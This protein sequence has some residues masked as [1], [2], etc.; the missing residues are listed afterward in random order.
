[1]WLKVTEKDKHCDA[2]T[3]CG[4]TSQNEL[5]TVADDKTIQQWNINAEFKKKMCELEHYPTSFSFATAQTKSIG[6]NFVVGFSNGM[7]QLVSK[8]GR[9]ERKVASAHKGA[10]LTCKFNHEGTALMTAG[11]DGFLK[12]WSKTGN[13]QSKLCHNAR[14]VYDLAWAP[15][16]QSV[17]YCSEKLLTIKPLSPSMKEV[18][19]K[20]HDA[21]VLAVDWNPINNLIISGGEDCRYKIWDSFGRQM[22]ASS[23]LEFT[24][25]SIAWANSGDV[26]AV[27]TYN[28]ILLCDRYGWAH[29][30]NKLRTGSI[31]SLAWTAD[32][33]QVAGA[34]ASGTVCFAQCLGKSK[35]WGGIVA[36]V[37]DLKHVHVVG[38]KDVAVN[39]SKLSISE[40]AEEVMRE[41]EELEFSDRVVEVS[42]GHGHVV[43]VTQTACYI[44]KTSTYALHHKFELSHGAITLLMMSTGIFLLAS[45]SKGVQIYST[46]GSLRCTPRGQHIAPARFLH[47][48]NTA[49]AADVLAH[50][51][52][53]NPREVI[54][55][56]TESGK[57]YAEPYTHSL[58]VAQIAF[59]QTASTSTRKL[60]II[61][62]NRDLYIT[63][64]HRPDAFKLAT[65]VDTAA[66]HS[67]SDVLACVSHQRLVT[68][69]YP[70]VVY[71]DRDLLPKIQCSTDA[72][73]Y[74]KQSQIV[75]FHG[76]TC[77]VQRADGT[78]MCAPVSPF[79]IA[80]IKY[81][82]ANKW[83]QC[84][85]LCRF[86]K[87]Q[88]LWACLA[89]VAMNRKQLEIAAIAFAAL[90]EV[91]KLECVQQVLSLP[92]KQAQ[93]AELLLFQ[94]KP[95]AAE[96][97]LLNANLIYRAI[98]LNIRVFRWRRAL[99]IALKYHKSSRISHVDTVLAHRERYLDNF[100]KKE[101]DKKFLQIRSKV[102][103][104]FEK[105]AAKEREERIAELKKTAKKNEKN[106]SV[107][108]NI[109][110]DTDKSAK[111]NQ[112]N[113]LHTS[114]SIDEG[115]M[116][117]KKQ[118]MQQAHHDDDKGAAAAGEMKA[119][120]EQAAAFDA[121]DD[122]EM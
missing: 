12:K 56:D 98:D 25:T 85:R 106:S 35:R 3:G 78:L 7:F 63:R 32:G 30:S 31:Y 22:Y 84:S 96:Q 117:E 104:D 20:A 45:T 115:G 94:R 100:N 29:S 73:Q 1:M 92:S 82:S 111:N 49:L 59:N 50:V 64:I 105:V 107:L 93:N 60:L 67:H 51:N 108:V 39:D 58:P 37:K 75:S 36:E 52:R 80:L 8:T 86:A 16:G 119:K 116:M 103:V 14:A 120:D 47:E 6:Q 44:Y 54:F 21:I 102:K 99:D 19:W 101:T 26:F 81:A 110:L 122:L 9:I 2:V 76:S 24:V 118:D 109:I 5:F 34:G 83:A 61:D 4:W 43:V 95:D 88:V 74:G 72:A 57:S 11:E 42:V 41:G 53:N 17:L 48:G 66:W 18:K 15:D 71:V 40:G 89:A 55:I 97:L 10:V 121:D 23:P 65:M 38:L 46:D 90:D 68:W 91:D 113:E 62:E 70:H 112:Q 33:T 27:G 28:R 114:A 87:Q 79:P 77:T 69:Y 13:L